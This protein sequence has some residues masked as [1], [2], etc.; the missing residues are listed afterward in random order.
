MQSESTKIF[1]NNAVFE[2]DLEKEIHKIY[3]D[4][5]IVFTFPDELYMDSFDDYIQGKI[6][7]SEFIKESNRKLN[8]YLK[9]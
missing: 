5:E 3:E 7:I 1:R 9:E 6:D 8:I 4:G 2:S